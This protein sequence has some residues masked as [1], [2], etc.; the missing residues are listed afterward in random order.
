MKLVFLGPP[1]A[2]KGTQA[3]R[4]AE[5]EHIA[6]ISSGDMLRTEIRKGT[7]AGLLAKDLIEKGEFVPDEII[8]EM[9]KDRILEPDCANGFLFDG[10]PRTVA[11]ADALKEIADIDAVIDIDVPFDRLLERIT[12]RRVCPN[13][14]MAYHISTYAGD[15]CEKCGEKLCQ[16]D[17]DTAETVQNRLTVYERLT[18]PLTEYYR[19]EGLLR[20][21]NGDLGIDEVTEQIRKA[22]R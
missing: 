12:G 15:T 2:G 5:S 21:V 7:E 19:K 22:I 10:F 20:I 9:V 13:C 11:Q 1:G 16:R 18:R 4:I 6:H 14:G 8:I 3:E 17:D